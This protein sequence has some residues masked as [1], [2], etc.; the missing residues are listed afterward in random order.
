MNHEFD[1]WLGKQA[2]PVAPDRGAHRLL[3]TRLEDRFRERRRAGRNRLSTVAVA[4]VVVLVTLLWDATP[5]VSFNRDL[6]LMKGR[7]DIL[8]S[9]GGASF[10]GYK[11]QPETPQEF[12]ET[13]QELRVAQLREFHS[14]WF[15]E[16]DGRRYW[17]SAYYYEIEGKRQLITSQ[18]REP[19]STLD[20]RTTMTA[21]KYALEVLELIPADAVRE[22]PAQLMR[23]DG[24][25]VWMRVWELETEH[26]LFRYGATLDPEP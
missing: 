17:T 11:I 12:W 26:G 2:E 14:A 22:L 23:V 8:V 4:A 19:V 13:I 3:K 16:L 10:G 9:P 25:D 1:R 18:A 24:R 5:L 6:V 7:D 20:I 21:N 15:V